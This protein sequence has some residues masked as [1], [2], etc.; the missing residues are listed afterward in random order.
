M[1]NLFQKIQK[2]LQMK[3]KQGKTER[4]FPVAKRVF[5]RLESNF[6]AKQ[7]MKLGIANYSAIAKSLEGEVQGSEDAIKVAVLRF[8]KQL[9]KLGDDGNLEAIQKVLQETKIALLSNISVLIFD[10]TPETES[11]A[12]KLGDPVFSLLSS[13]H[14]VLVTT[15]DENAKQIEKKLGEHNLIK[16]RSSLCMLRL[17]SPPEIED[18]PGVVAFLLDKLAEHSVNVTDLY[19]CY[20]DTNLLIERNDAMKAFELIE[21]MC[22][23]S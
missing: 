11:A 13:E 14:A 15:F 2:V 21:G 3:Q 20:T 10:K 22:K 7:A 4:D 8:A 16:K 19:S 6:Y 18:I 23:K 9:G 17:T 5:E 1:T 12:A